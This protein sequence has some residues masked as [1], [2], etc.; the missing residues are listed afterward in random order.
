MEK[1]LNTR[2]KSEIEGLTSLSDDTG[3][4]NMS[5]SFDDASENVNSEL[6]TYPGSPAQE[7]ELLDRRKLKNGVEGIENELL[8]NQEIDVVLEVDVTGELIISDDEAEK[9]FID[10]EAE[11]N[12][13]FE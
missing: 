9:F 7:I 2:S 11:L 8:I 6:V 3:L 5:V 1:T 4:F 13:K 10:D 12:F